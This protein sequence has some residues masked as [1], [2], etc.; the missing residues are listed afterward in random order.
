[1]GMVSPTTTANEVDLRNHSSTQRRNDVFQLARGLGVGTSFVFV[2]D[3]DPEALYDQLQ[4][5][6]RHEFFWNYLATAPKLW[7]VQIGRLQKAD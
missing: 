6:H 3:H 5:E 4:K 1:M 7:R 2:T